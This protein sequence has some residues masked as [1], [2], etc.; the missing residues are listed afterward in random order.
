MSDTKRQPK[1]IE[2][3]DN[4]G[5]NQFRIVAANGQIIGRSE[6]GKKNLKHMRKMAV[7]GAIAIIEKYKPELLKSEKNG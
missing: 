4:N 5:D 3:K 1:V 7:V 6:E 2:Y